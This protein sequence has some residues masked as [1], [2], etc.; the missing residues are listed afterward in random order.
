MWMLPGPWQDSQPTF[1][2]LS[3]G[4][5]SRVCVAVLKSFTICSWHCEQVSEPT[6]SAPGMFGG[7]ITVRLTAAHE[8]ADTVAVAIAETTSTLRR[9]TFRFAQLAAGAEELSDGA[10][11]EVSCETHGKRPGDSRYSAKGFHH[12]SMTWLIEAAIKNV[13]RVAYSMEFRLQLQ[14]VGRRN[15]QVDANPRPAPPKGGSLNLPDTLNRNRS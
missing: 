11:M 7:A 10:F 8:I 15:F 13:G 5:F 3:P 12:S 1:L 14:A 4:A 9:L 2:A 6:N